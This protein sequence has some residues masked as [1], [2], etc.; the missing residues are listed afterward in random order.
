[1]CLSFGVLLDFWPFMT[2]QGERGNPGSAGAAGAQGPIGARG[3]AGTP[4]PDGNKVCTQV[5]TR[6]LDQRSSTLFLGTHSP[7]K[8]S[9]NPNQT[10]LK[11]PIKLLKTA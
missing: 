1:M 3:P 10:H 9:Y 6:H 2:F 11:Q 7:E 4:G 8:F 5:T